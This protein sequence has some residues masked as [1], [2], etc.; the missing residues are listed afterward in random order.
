M[1]ARVIGIGEP[2]AGDDA[3]GLAVAQAVQA[4]GL[5]PGVEVH[6][7]RDPLAILPLLDGAEVVILVDAL[8]DGPP[9]RVV[10]LC[11]GAIGDHGGRALSSHGLG[12][13][14]VLELATELGAGRRRPDVRIVAVTIATPVGSGPGLSPAVA[15]AVPEAAQ[16]ALAVVNVIPR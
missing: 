9:G 12:L 1:A 6:G 4:I 10:E 14:Q 2:A 16:R 8:A 3:V 5:P 13:R 7:V 11:P 15:A